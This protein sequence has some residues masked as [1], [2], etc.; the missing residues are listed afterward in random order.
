MLLWSF[1]CIGPS[2][3]SS[4]SMSISSSSLNSYRPSSQS[5]C[6]SS[7]SQ[8]SE[9]VFNKRCLLIQGLCKNVMD[10]TFSALSTYFGRSQI[11]FPRVK[12]LFS[13]RY[14]D[15]NQDSFSPCYSKL[16]AHLHS[17]YHSYIS[18]PACCKILV[19][20]GRFFSSNFLLLSIYSYGCT[21]FQIIKRH[22]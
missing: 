13:T 21:P 12:H 5:L 11:H 20:D 10:L 9:A 14:R 6:F 22:F 8:Y 4:M 17:H 3:I 1:F 19:F 2:N 16:A 18:C 15:S 7:S